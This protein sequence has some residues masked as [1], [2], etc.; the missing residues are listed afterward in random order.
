MKEIARDDD[1]LR[2]RLDHA[3]DGQ[4]ERLGDIR[5]ALVDAGGR[6]PVILPDAEVRIGDV[7][8]FHP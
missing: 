1:Q 2:P 8:D 5:L 6:L 4:A 3:L 7:R